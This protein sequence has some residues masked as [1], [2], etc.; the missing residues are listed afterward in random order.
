MDYTVKAQTG[1]FLLAGLAALM[2]VIFIYRVVYTFV[3]FPRSLRRY[4][5][6]KRKERGYTS[7]TRGLAAVAAGDAR[8]AS[9]HAA[10]TAKLLPEDTGL[11]FLLRAQAAKL[12]GDEETAKETFAA[13]I[14]NKDAGFFG[15]RGLLQLALEADDYDASLELGH[16]A[17]RIH[18][19]QPWILKLV[20]DLEIERRNWE[21]AKAILYRA[22]RAAAIPSQQAASDRIAILLAQAEESRILR[23]RNKTSSYLQQAY[24]FHPYFA[25][26]ALALARFYK[27]QN[28][29]RKAVAVIERT[30]RKNPHPD[31]A[32]FWDFLI[33]PNK[34]NK[35]MARMG[36]YEKLAAYNPHAA[37]SHL[38]LGRV[39]LEEGLW[40][41]ARA[42]FEQAE[43]IEPSAG[44]Y[45]SWME[46]E[47]HASSR[48]GALNELQH[49][50]AQHPLEKHW[51]C[52]DT[53]AIY[54]EWSPLAELHGSFNTIEWVYPHGAP[55]ALLSARTAIED[56]L[57]E[58]PRA[59]IA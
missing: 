3:D 46:L 45:R 1:F 10:R 47:R 35:P 33:P 28:N 19:R 52:R 53:G 17:L 36:W 40:G 14:N 21:D 57:L 54:E 30:W 2:T 4:L 13:L 48:P 11:P 56:A 50:L 39:A 51:V 20:Y 38:M 43:K 37:E 27:G 44:L 23:L 25:P 32:K 26:A 7:L 8:V 49:K 29:R 59:K 15:V 58:S 31:L 6:L 41:E 16:R 9:Y 24:R 34:A 55:S 18:P 5:E 12:K 22:E 42:H